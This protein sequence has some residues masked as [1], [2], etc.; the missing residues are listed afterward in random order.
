MNSTVFDRSQSAVRTK[1]TGSL[2]QF[3]DAPTAMLEQLRCHVTTVNA[4]EA[5]HTPHEH[6]DEELIIVEDGE[7]TMLMNGSE[8]LVSAGSMAFVAAGQWHGI[9]N[10][11]QAP[12]TYYVVRWRTKT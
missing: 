4:G 8:Q 7:I 10:A 3:I 5:S 2:R 6:P 1:A 12:A 11:G 9:R